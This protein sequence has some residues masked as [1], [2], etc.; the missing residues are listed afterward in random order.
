MDGGVRDRRHPYRQC[1]SEVNAWLIVLLFLSIVYKVVTRVEVGGLN[2]M[3][4]GGSVTGYWWCAL[5]SIPTAPCCIFFWRT[6]VRKTTT[7]LGFWWFFK[8]SRIGGSSLAILVS[9][10]YR[11]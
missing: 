4:A 11:S 8:S 7:H 10:K 6:F 3:R 5:G 9:I 2:L 1:V